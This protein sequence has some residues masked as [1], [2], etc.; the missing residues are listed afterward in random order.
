M[1]RVLP[2]TLNPGVHI[3]SLRK[4]QD[5]E[6]H[7]S[8]RLKSM[9][10]RHSF[11][12][13]RIFFI[14]FLLFFFQRL[15]LAQ[16]CPSS[17]NHSQTASENTYYYSATGT[18]AA[19][20]SS[21]TL[22]A[23]P[24][25]YGSTPIAAGDQVLIIQMQGAQIK[26]TNVSRYGSSSLTGSGMLTTNLIAGNMEFAI[27]NSAV[28]VTGGV[29]TL[30]APISNTYIDSPYSTNGQYTYQIIRVPAWFNIQ[31]T[32][33]VSSPVWNGNVG[34]VTIISAV[35]QL[36]FNGQ[37]INALGAG[38]RGG[39]G[40]KLTG[41]A[42]TSKNDYMTLATTNANG[43]KGEGIAGTPRYINNRGVVPFD[44]ILE[45]YP[46]GSYARGAPANAGG[47]G[48]DGDPTSNDQNS[49]GGG[50]GNGGS[51]GQGGNGWSLAATTG[52]KGGSPFTTP[53]PY[54]AYY[55]PARLIL[56]GG[57]GAG[58]TNDATGTPGSG[59][60]SSGSAGGGL[61]IVTAST[62]I[63]TG[64]INANG[65]AGN[66]T[67]IID[68]SG[69][70]GAGGSVLIYAAAGLSN[71]T[72][73]AVGGTG[74][75]NDPGSVSATQHGPG[76]GGGGGVIYSN[77][78]LNA[79]SS[80]IGGNAG[81]SNSTA[82]SNNFGAVAGANGILVQNITIS[83]LPPNM[84]TCQGTIVL[85]IDLLNFNAAYQS[86][87]TV[88]VSW[89]ASNEMNTSYFE[90]ERSVDGADFS[91]LGNVSVN[92]STGESHNYSFNDYLQAVKSPV[93][94]YRL[95]MVNT[96]G[97]FTYSK[98]VVVSLDQTDATFSIFP[99]PATDYAVLR[100]YSDKQSVGM[101][102]LMDN[103][104]REIM[105]K[106]FTI[107]TGN[108]SMM[109]DQLNTLPKGVYIVQVVFNNSLYNNKLIKQ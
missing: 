92:T 77:A 103:S 95:K 89:T 94:Y 81:I 65:A 50:G 25:G 69:G 54:T 24:A 10:K 40:R 19:G 70:G 6:I 61:V 83:Q 18:L 53:A 26:D 85:P 42:G 98:T 44:N 28:P 31:L 57:G 100:F 107:N 106:S 67:P 43:S 59:F 51:G 16:T 38:F 101:M 11:L 63:G 90:V 80:A 7:G 22:N 46:G 82:V 56:G 109:V 32:A 33:T 62:I 52:G 76:G 91:F 55:N 29:L 39:A 47:G 86:S 93:F 14:A 60:A 75:S 34:G 2:Y 5:K 105:Y 79:A 104:G 37:T 4:Q 72:V 58:T 87:N 71:I 41:A 73:T 15:V 68:G 88:L 36:D 35:N 49:G 13:A 66:N 48:T 1:K 23:V 102:R 99:N 96:D 30:S 84:E 74:G 97:S 78:T 9:I 108:N 45:G 27:A 64:T 8:F 17:G 12:I 21:I 3:P 20:S